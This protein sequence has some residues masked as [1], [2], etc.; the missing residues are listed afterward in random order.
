MA[1]EMTDGLCVDIG[2]GRNKVPGCLGID[3]A[4]DV[5]ADIV[6]D[7][8]KGIPLPDN[9]VDELHCS[10]VLEHLWNCDP[11]LLEMA[12]ICKPGASLFFRV[13]DVHHDSYHCPTH[14][15]PWS[16]Y[17]WE[18]HC[19]LFDV[20]RVSG[21]VDAEA[22]GRIQRYLPEIT[23]ED[24]MDLFWNVRKELHIWCRGR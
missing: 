21:E 20:V 24:A 8:T 9:S 15:Q 16:R 11:A 17:W 12:R 13:P 6:C 19:T 1:W 4:D 10:H 3:I 18:E 7:I 22:F 5:G 23:E 14:C 2:C